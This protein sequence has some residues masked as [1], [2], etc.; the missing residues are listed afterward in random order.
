MTGLRIIYGY[1]GPELCEAEKRGEVELGGCCVGDND[2]N[3]HCKACDHEW[4][5]KKS[6]Q[7]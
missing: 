7:A 3:F 1:P 6:E 2:P 4:R 5:F